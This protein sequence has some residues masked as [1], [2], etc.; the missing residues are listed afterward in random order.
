[1]HGQSRMRGRAESHRRGLRYHIAH[2]YDSVT[3]MVV[4]FCVNGIHR[5]ND[6]P[7]V[8]ELLRAQQRPGHRLSVP[9]AAHR[10]A[11]P[12]PTVAEVNATR[13]RLVA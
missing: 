6:A 8:P 9:A 5:A 4:R 13:G 12:G 1:M 2:Q 7:N 3:T 11:P 10:V